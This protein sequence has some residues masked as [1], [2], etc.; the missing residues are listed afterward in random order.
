MNALLVGPEPSRVLRNALIRLNIHTLQRVGGRN[1]AVLPWIF[2]PAVEVVIIFAE[3]ASRKLA[4]A[5][6]RHAGKRSIPVLTCRP[7]VGALALAWCALQRGGRRAGT[8]AA[9]LQDG[10]T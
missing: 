7:S 4:D 9:G 6:R 3:S 8:P 1:V 10:R 5:V 2:T